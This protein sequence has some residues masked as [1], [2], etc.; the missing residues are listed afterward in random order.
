MF[1]KRMFV[2][3]IFRGQK[4]YVNTQKVYEG[5]KTVLLFAVSAALFIAGY[6]A[7]KS[8]MNLLTIVAVLGC[9]PASKSLVNLIMFLRFKSAPADLIQ[10]IEAKS[11]N[12]PA[13]YDN[14]FTTY[15]KSYFVDHLVFRQNNLVCFAK[16]C[17]DIAKLEK[18]LNEKLLA[19]G[20]KGITVKIFDNEAKYL[21]R[22]TSLNELS[23]D[24][25]G[26]ADEIFNTIRAICL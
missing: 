21:E 22:L 12:L 11:G 17:K 19:G 25:D 9:L 8:R 5:I 16:E 24:N 26:N 10:R 13:L 7:T 15:E 6:I 1:F 3:E 20:H 23:S 2:P 4:N 18:H 14:I